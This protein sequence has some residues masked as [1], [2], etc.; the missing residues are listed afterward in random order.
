MTGKKQNERND[1]EETL[2]DLDVPEGQADS[3]RGGL[4]ADSN[5]VAVEGFR[6]KQNQGN[7]S[8]TW[9]IKSNP[10]V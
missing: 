2:S 4:K 8:A 5:E 10:K 7:V 9:D 6:P 1:R 3:V